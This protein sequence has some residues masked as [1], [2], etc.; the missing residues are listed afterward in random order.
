MERNNQS[1]QSYFEIV[2]RIVK[3]FGGRLLVGLG[4]AVGFLFFSAGSPK[5]FLKAK[6]KILTNRSE[7]SFTS[8]P[9]RRSLPR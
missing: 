9:R 3:S 4:F 1:N 6:R 5:R 2:G 8:L 7:I